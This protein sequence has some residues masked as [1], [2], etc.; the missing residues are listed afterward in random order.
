MLERPFAIIIG[1]S[2]DDEAFSTLLYAHRHY[3]YLLLFSFLTSFLSEQQ[4]LLIANDWFLFGN[5][6]LTI[7]DASEVPQSVLS[8]FNLIVLGAFH[9]VSKLT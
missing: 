2:D 1:H 6:N 3:H 7:W 8:T 4:A 5:G 9:I